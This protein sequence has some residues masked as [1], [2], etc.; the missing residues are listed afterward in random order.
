MELFFSGH[1]ETIIRE[2]FQ[3]HDE[4]PINLANSKTPGQDIIQFFAAAKL[5]HPWQNH[6]EEGDFLIKDVEEVIVT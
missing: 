2:I 3:T 5:F 4:V 6:L 1:S